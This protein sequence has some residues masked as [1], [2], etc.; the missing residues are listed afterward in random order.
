MVRTIIL[1]G[2]VI[3]IVLTGTMILPGLAIE[4]VLASSGEVDLETRQKALASTV[5]ILLLVPVLDEQGQPVII[6]N[7]GERQMQYQTGE[8]MGTLARMNNELVIITHDHWTLLNAQLAKARFYNANN[9]LLVEVSGAEFVGLI[10]SRDG[11]T[12]VLAAP[13]ALLGR[14]GLAA[15]EIGNGQAAGWG[16]TVA[17]VYRNP[18]TWALDVKVMAVRETADYQGR[19]SFVLQSSE[20]TIVIPGNSGGGIWY[21]GGLVGNMWTTMVQD[22]VADSSSETLNM[23]RAAQLS[24]GG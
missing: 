10:R 8:G 3:T 14:S 20:G 1:I 6:E 19:A 24:V 18:A 13:I 17:V 11:G 7:G 2:I 9:D 22:N 12:M 23:S 15:A 5:Q 16:E 4:A 21:N